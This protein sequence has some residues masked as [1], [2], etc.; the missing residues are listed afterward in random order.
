M[1]F[2]NNPICHRDALHALLTNRLSFVRIGFVF[3]IQRI[4]N[5]RQI[6]DTLRSSIPTLAAPAARLARPEGDSGGFPLVPAH[7]R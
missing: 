6:T 7:V 4:A 3:L 2:N 5:A 1:L